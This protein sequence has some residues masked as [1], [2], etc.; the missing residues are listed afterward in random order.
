MECTRTI[1]CNGHDGRY[2]VKT[3]WLK[4]PINNSYKLKSCVAER[5]GKANRNGINVLEIISNHRLLKIV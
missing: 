5:V 1:I 4:Q 3:V 2:K